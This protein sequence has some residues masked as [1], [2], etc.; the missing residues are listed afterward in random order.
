MHVDAK[1]PLHFELSYLVPIGTIN[2]THPSPRFREGG[3]LPS[4]FGQK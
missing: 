4:R 1:M 2:I 3:I